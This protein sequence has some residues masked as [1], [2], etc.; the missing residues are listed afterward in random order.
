MRAMLRSSPFPPSSFRELATTATSAPLLELLI[1]H[2]ASVL[3]N[4]LQEAQ[5]RRYHETQEDLAV[6]RGRVDFPYQARR[7]PSDAHRIRVRYAPLQRDNPLSQVCRA[8]VEALLP[9]S[10]VATHRAALRGCLNLMDGVTAVPLT[11]ELIQIAAPSRM[12]EEW[13]WV[14]DLART[15]VSGRSPDPTTPGTDNGFSILFPLDGLFEGLVRHALTRGLK[16][17]G[18]SLR[19]TRGIGHLFRRQ[20]DGVELINLKP[21]FV[22]SDDSSDIAFAVGDAKWKRAKGGLNSALQRTDAFQLTTYMARSGVEQGF[23]CFPAVAPLV[24]ICRMQRIE[25]QR[26][27]WSVALIEVDAGK[28]AA[29]DR[30]VRSGAEKVLAEFIL[31]AMQHGDSYSAAAGGAIGPAQSS[32]TA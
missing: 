1:G 17:S 9:Q 23:L 13:N 12:E 11:P 28:L 5:P 14:V 29:R 6:I 3:F 26:T 22:V 30:I 7:A 4:Q 10:T 8:V 24:E 15:L 27:G 19:R 32:A 25:T 18:C 2:V 16:G 21:D 20:E 31:Q